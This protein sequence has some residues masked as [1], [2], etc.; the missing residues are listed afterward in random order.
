VKSAVTRVGYRDLDPNV[1][2]PSR[3]F[4]CLPCHL[5]KVV[6]ENLEGDRAVRDLL[7]NLAG[8]TLIIADAG[9]AHQCRIGRK[10]LDIR[11]GIHF[12]HTRLLRPIGEDGDLQVADRFHVISRSSLLCGMIQDAA[13]SKEA[14]LTVGAE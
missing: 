4:T 2:P 7:Q 5:G 8:E 9:L 14:T 13:P 11:L 6:G 12:E 3:D 10:A 1:F